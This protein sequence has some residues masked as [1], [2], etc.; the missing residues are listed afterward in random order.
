VNL[1][2]VRN[3]V[4]SRVGR[5]LLVVQKHSPTIMFGAGV[6]GV[7]TAAVLASR[8]TL[9]LEETLDD[10][11]RDLDNAKALNNKSPEL[12]SND[13]FQRDKII[14]TTKTAIK[15]VK[16]Y[17]PAILVGAASIAALTGSHV[18]L[19]RRFAGVT[20]AY[21][22][23]EQGF[24]KY[25][26]RVVNEYGPEKDRELRYGL[27]DKEIV[28]ETEEGPVKR[29]VKGLANKDCSIYARFFDE[30]STSWNKIPSY[31]QLFIRCQQN[32]ANDLLRSRGHVFL[33]EVYDMLGLER[34]K[35]GAVVGWVLDGNGDGFI[36]FGVF[37][38]SEWMGQLFVNGNERSV[39]LDFNVDGVIYDK[40]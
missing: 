6:V 16:L 4:T 22:A 39:L 1:R 21:A 7:V 40:I 32:Y 28:E 10:I 17:G 14:M 11:Q 9:K 35:E 19:N 20:A 12:Y 31:N 13:D 2:A 27:V 3:A 18:T 37:S 24:D 29:T 25:R 15:V 26:R 23:L 38:G 33:N 34:S 36:D 5:Q 8:A 30:T